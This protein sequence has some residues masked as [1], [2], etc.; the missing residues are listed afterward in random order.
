[1]EEIA[2][3]WKRECDE[4]RKFADLE[5]EAFQSV[6]DEITNDVTKTNEIVSSLNEKVGSLQ[7]EKV[8]LCFFDDL[9]LVE[10]YLFP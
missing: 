9:S 1:L 7:S 6:I 10:F 2:N 8:F 3:V 4:L 5:R